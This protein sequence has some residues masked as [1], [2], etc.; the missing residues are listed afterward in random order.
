MDSRLR[1]NEE[2]LRRGNEEDEGKAATRRE[3]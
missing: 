2:N 1:G 3:I